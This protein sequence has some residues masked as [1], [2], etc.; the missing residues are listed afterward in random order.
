VHD[1]GQN[2]YLDTVRGR[3]GGIRLMRKPRK[4]LSSLLLP[5]LAAR[6]I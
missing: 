1:L 5:E 6:A 4:A 2:G 3:N